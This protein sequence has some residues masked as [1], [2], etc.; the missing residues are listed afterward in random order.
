MKFIELFAGIGGMRKGAEAQGGTCVFACEIDKFARQSYAANF[1][2][3]FLVRQDVRHVE[4]GEIPSHDLLLAGFPCQPFSHAGLSKKRSLGQPTGFLDET[5]G[6]LF[7]NIATILQSHRPP[8]FI[9]EN[10]PGILQHNKGRTFS[11]IHRILSKELNYSV[12]WRI[13]NSQPWVPQMRRRLFL[14]G[15]RD[16]SAGPLIDT[17]WPSVSQGG[18]KIGSIL[19]AQVPDKY[20]L[21]DKTWRSLQRHANYHKSKNNGFGYNLHGPDDV[22]HTLSARYYKDGSEILIRQRRKNPR[23]LTPRECSR[24]MGFDRDGDEFRIVVSDTQAYKQFGN[25]VVP[26]VVQEILRFAT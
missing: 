20:T 24:L 25:A 21:R 3:D 19:D 11:T 15:A 9:L 8:L 17:K 2:S 26:A 22:A 12:A 23:R 13:L 10:V 14:L 4:M 16:M 18:T 6:T 1:S 7:F 5:Q